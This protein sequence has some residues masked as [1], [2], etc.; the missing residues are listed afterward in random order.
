VAVLQRARRAADSD[1]HLVLEPQ[2]QPI[3]ADLGA[4]IDLDHEPIATAARVADHLRRVRRISI[5]TTPR[6]PDGMRDGSSWM[7]HAIESF[8]GTVRFLTDRTQHHRAM[9]AIRR[10]YLMF[11][12]LSSLGKSLP[13]WV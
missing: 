13:H 12:Q 1:P 2:T 7:S 8:S 9:A 3:D 10:K 11:R 5:S 6:S 4:V